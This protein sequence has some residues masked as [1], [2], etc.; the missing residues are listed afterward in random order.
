MMHMASRS[1]RVSILGTQYTVRYVGPENKTLADRGAV[2]YTNA[3]IKTI[4]ILDTRQD[5]SC[6]HFKGHLSSAIDTM[7]HEVIHA[8]LDQSGLGGNSMSVRAWA[9]NE[10]MIDWFA[11]QWPR[12]QLV[13]DQ[14]TAWLHMLHDPTSELYFKVG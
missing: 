11:I 6:S 2:G 5:P 1:K 7:R 8:F 4:L 13:I 9:E 10:E 14:L 12:I 3:H